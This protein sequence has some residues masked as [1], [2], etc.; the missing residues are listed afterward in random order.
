M[1]RTGELEQWKKGRQ[2]AISGL[3]RAQGNVPYTRGYEEALG[4]VPFF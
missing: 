2:D 3:P 4:R 1:G